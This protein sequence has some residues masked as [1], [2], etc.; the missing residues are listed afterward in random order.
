MRISLWA[1]LALAGHFFI[2]VAGHAQQV[3]EWLM[4]LKL[5]N[6]AAK[7]I[8]TPS[9]WGAAYG[10]I[11]LGAGAAERTPY[12]PSADGIVGIGYGMGDPVLT[13]GLQIGTTVSDLSE[14]DNVSFSFKV[15]RY[16]TKGTSIAFGAES[17]F[18]RDRLADDAGDTFYLVASH[19]LQ[20]FGSSGSGIGRV[21]VSAGVGTG[22][23]AE[24]SERDFSEGK[25]K[26]GTMAFGNVAVGVARDVN[27]IVEWSGTNLITGMSTTIHARKIPIALSIGLADLTGYSGDGVRVVGAA[28]VALA[29]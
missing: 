15:H 8:M 13:A 9:G 4:S 24:K 7:S 27:V 25:G 19:I 21:H 22:R 3:P 29:F 28:A 16:L 20:S 26:D 5:P 14:F 18:S 17:L 2:P 12:L 1:A 11:Y 23:F 10:S 6:A